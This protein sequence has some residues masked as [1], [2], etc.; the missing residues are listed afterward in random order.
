MPEGILEIS[1]LAERPV[2]ARSQK[3]QRQSS[4]LRLLKQTEAK[5]SEFESY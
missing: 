2:R 1:A 5:S 3:A 4:P